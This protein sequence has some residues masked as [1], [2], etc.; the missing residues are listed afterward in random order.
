MTT[1]FMFLVMFHYLTDDYPVALFDDIEKA[2]AYIKTA[3]DQMSDSDRNALNG[4][5]DADSLGYAIVHFRDGKPVKRTV[6]R[7]FDNEA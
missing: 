7:W 4:L 5:D 1:P 2:L 3:P 6:E